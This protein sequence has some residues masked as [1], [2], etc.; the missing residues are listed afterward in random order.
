[1]EPIRNYYKGAID[2]T[3]EE[4][5]KV[6]NINI[7]FCLLWKAGANFSYLVKEKKRWKILINS[8]KVLT[9]EDPI[10]TYKFSRLN[11]IQFLKELV[12]RI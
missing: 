10:S 2:E 12:G 6:I 3:I 9:L 8:F 11:S 5:L 1:M 4:T 7:S